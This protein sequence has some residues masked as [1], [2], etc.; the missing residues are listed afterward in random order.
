MTISFCTAAGRCLFATFAI[1]DTFLLRM[2]L[3]ERKEES[4]AGGV[5]VCFSRSRPMTVCA[6]RS[7]FR[8]DAWRKPPLATV[9]FMS[10]CAAC[11]SWPFEEEEKEWPG[12]RRRSYFAFIALFN[13]P[14]SY[15]LSLFLTATVAIVPRA[16][17]VPFCLLTLQPLT[18]CDCKRM[19]KHQYNTTLTVL[20]VWRRNPCCLL[21]LF[22]VHPSIILGAK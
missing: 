22:Y 12:V 18:V 4:S 20:S 9:L 13:F 17:K 2:R 1:A 8:F 21:L 15:S 11:A 19:T 3:K 6:A 5:V 7:L 14:R 10:A 16:Y